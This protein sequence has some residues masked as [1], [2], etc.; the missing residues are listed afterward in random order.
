VLADM[1]WDIRGVGDFNGD[2]KP[3]LQW[4]N[5]STGDVAVWTFNNQQRISTPWM[6]LLSGLDCRELDGGPG[7]GA[8]P[9]IT[10]EIRSVDLNGRM[11]LETRWSSGDQVVTRREPYRRQ[12]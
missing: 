3:D 11:V 9:I 12:Q 10:R 2:G 7:G 6:S 5:Q 1:N 8:L 4:H